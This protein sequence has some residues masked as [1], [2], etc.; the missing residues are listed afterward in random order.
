MVWILVNIDGSKWLF[1]FPMTKEAIPISAL[2]YAVMVFFMLVIP[3]TKLAI[4]A[5]Q[6]GELPTDNI[7]PSAFFRKLPDNPYLLSACW[8][9]LMLLFTLVFFY[10]VFGM[11]HWDQLNF[12]QFFV[13]RLCLIKILA[14]IIFSLSFLKYAQPEVEY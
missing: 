13:V 12:F 3:V 9:I 2:I 14:K 6:A 1:I 4:E 10:G 11:M 5:K 7:K 8:F